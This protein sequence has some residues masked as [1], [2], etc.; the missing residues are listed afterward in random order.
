MKKINVLFFLVGLVFCTAQNKAVLYDFYE[1]PQALL[2][3][4]G[5]KTPY[6]WHAGVPLLSG[7]S[8]Q[9]GTSGVTVNDLFANDGVDFNTKIRERAI[10]SMS[11]RDEFSLSGQ[12]ELFTVGFRGKNN[13]DNYYSFG[14]YGEGFFSQF[15]PQDLAIL[16]FEGNATNIGRRFDLSHLTNQ[17]E[18]VNVLHFGV[19][20]RL[21][22]DWTIGARAKLY[23]SVLEFKTKGNSGYFETTL[24]EQNILRNTVV[25]DLSLETSGLQEFI[26]IIDEDSN[27]TQEDLINKFIS[28][29]LFG[30]NL[31]L[32]FDVGFTHNLS[33]NTLVT[34]SLLDVGLIYHNNAVK[35]YSVTGSANN[36]GLEIIL[37]DDLA[38]FNTDLWQELVDDIEQQVDY[39]TD[40]SSWV[41]LRPVKLYA[42]IRHNFGNVS[43]KTVR[44]D[45]CGCAFNGAG[46]SGSSQNI[47]YKNAVGAQ[48]FMINRP[49]GPQAALSAFYQK[50]LGNFLALK[51]TY[52]IDK[53]SLSNIGLGLNFQAGPVNFYIMGDNLLG[54]RNVADS[55]YAS[56]QFGFN[57]LSW[58]DN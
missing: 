9:A 37:P 52:T 42:S 4:P 8:M 23:S 17:G 2:L 47:D 40:A 58:N 44:R 39:N 22:E 26:D 21:D 18:V 13:P 54:Y 29:S 48:L 50:R 46:S 43:G 53:Y 55:H 45:N 51:T 32:G 3:N 11:Q 57:I 33:A 6:K 27:T 12:L 20:K 14:M 38:N 56:L 24:G 16:A 25:A 49:K 10:Y 5:V 31:G 41:S 1:V 34:G 30:G 7:F 36:E 19:N 35:N 15:W 28:R